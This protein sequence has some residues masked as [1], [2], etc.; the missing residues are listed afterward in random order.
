MKKFALGFVVLSLLFLAV[1]GHALAESYPAKPIVF[2]VPFTPGGSNDVLARLVAQKL[3]E[4]WGQPVVVENRVGGGGNIG[5]QFVT[6][7]AP[8]GYTFLI[9]ANTLITINPSV[10]SPPPFDTFKDFEPVAVMGAVP[11]LLVV[12]PSLP[13]KSVKE[14]AALI[15]AKPGGLTYG[16][17]GVGAPQHMTAELFSSA[18]GGSM[19]HVIYKGNAT[20]I[21]DLL[22]GQ[23]QVLFSP[24]NSILPHVKSGGVRALGIAG[25]KRSASLPDVPTID[26]EGMRGIYGESWISLVAPKGISPVI[27]DKMN[28]EI[29]KILADPDVVSNL[30]MQGIEPMTMT[31]A[32]FAVLIRNDFDRW[33]KLV[34]ALGLSIK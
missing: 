17:A 27:V 15:K 11:T 32:E 13:A 4:K 5:A 20:I 3:S 23:I 12:T 31:P 34:K 18:I 9:A 33:A 6:R 22:S 19:V 8:D 30:K 26:E 10:Y 21:P 29:T 14:L 28:R 1:A 2:I 16:S 7:C 24:I 25:V